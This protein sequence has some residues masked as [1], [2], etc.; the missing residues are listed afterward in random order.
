ME[1]RE[2]KLH[3]DTD[4]CFVLCYVPSIWHMAQINIWWM[5]LEL[6][7]SVLLLQKYSL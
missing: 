6:G 4:V 7:V 2:T 1:Y 5:R 3:E